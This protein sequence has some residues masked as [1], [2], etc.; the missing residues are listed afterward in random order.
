MKQ[1]LSTSFIPLFRLLK[2]ASNV[3]V[4]STPQVTTLDNV[5]AFIEVGENAPVGLTSTT[6]TGLTSQNSVDRKDITL[7]LDIVPR[8][9]PESGTVQ[10]DIKQKFD[11]FSNRSSSASE[12]ASRGV[13]IVKRNIETKMVLH[14]GEETAVLGGLLTDKEIHSETKVPL[15]GDIPVLGW[16]FKGSNVTKEKRNLLVFITPTI[17]KGREQ[18]QKTKQILGKKLEE[19]INF[20]QKYM[21]GKDPH[22]RA[23]ET[24]I[25]ESKSI[26][27]KNKKKKRKKI[28]NGFF[29]KTCWK[30]I[31]MK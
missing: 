3:N 17:I 30:K 13:H 6:T 18:K 31:L 2:T 8:I 27:E 10:M 20:I 19:R 26:R 25:P 9:N 24:L 22:G 14:D 15:L 5:R 4:L 11:D 21:K 28:L 16:L 29:K 1:T 7:K 12:L 23:L